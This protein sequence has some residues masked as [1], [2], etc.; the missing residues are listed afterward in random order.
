MYEQ[1]ELQ[2]SFEITKKSKENDRVMYVVRE[3][4]LKIMH[5][6]LAYVWWKILG[7]KITQ[8]YK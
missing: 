7:F 2:S 3:K 6:F 8:T 4:K 1:L 5:C